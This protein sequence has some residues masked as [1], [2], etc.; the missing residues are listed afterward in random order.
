MDQKMITFLSLLA[1]LCAVFLVITIPI[2]IYSLIVHRVPKALQPIREGL[3]E[4]ALP[5]AAAVAVVSTLGSLYLSE[6]AKFIPCE[7]CWFQRIFMYP[8]AIILTIAAFRK[9]VSIRIYALPLALVGAA[10]STYHYLIQRFP[11]NVSYE[12]ST[13]VSCDAVFVWKFHFLSIPGMA[14]IGFITIAVLLLLANRKPALKTGSGSA[15]GT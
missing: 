2:A 15:T 14:W 13:E 10:I 9:D 7:L 8:L 1:V 11:E 6:A 3:G 12:C 4:V 5:M